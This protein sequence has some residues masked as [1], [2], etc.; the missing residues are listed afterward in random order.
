M[1]CLRRCALAF[2]LIGVLLVGAA[3][4]IAWTAADW[5]STDDTL[6]KAD[7]IVVLGHDPTRVFHAADLYRQGV[8]PLVVLSRP[9]RQKKG[10]LL[11]SQGFPI[12]WFEVAGAKIL[13]DRGVPA[14]AIRVIDEEVIS[15]VTE[16]I[17][18]GRELPEAKRMVVVTSPSHVFR[19]R[20]IFRRTLPD[21]AIALV[22][23]RYETLDRAWW[24]EQEDAQA[25]LMEF[26][27]LPFFLAGGRMKPAQ[28]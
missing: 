5:L 13:A 14:A 10:L 25:V 7:A 4:S 18:F 2:L 28:P 9:K 24:R 3:L 16:A 1:Q 8:A 20:L 22:G 17:A 11:E 12:H 15:T 6:E 26:V 21:R 19:S 23:S 27:K